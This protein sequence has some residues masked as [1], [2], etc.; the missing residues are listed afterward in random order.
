MIWSAG[1]LYLLPIKNG[2]ALGGSVFAFAS[3]HAI[4]TYGE[5]FGAADC[6]LPLNC[7]RYGKTRQPV[8]LDLWPMTCDPAARFFK[9]IG[10]YRQ[11]GSDVEYNG[12][13]L[14]RIPDVPRVRRRTSP[15]SN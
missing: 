9:M 15:W 12:E 2:L 3:H 5:N 13:T 6:G 1:G 11:D 4:L 8:D 7:I 10:N 14:R